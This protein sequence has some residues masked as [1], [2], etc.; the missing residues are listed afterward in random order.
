MKV[1]GVIHLPH[2][3]LFQTLLRT[4]SFLP[5]NQTHGV[6]RRTEVEE[7]PQHSL[8]R[9]R[10][11]DLRQG[12]HHHHRQ[13]LSHR[14]PLGNTYQHRGHLYLRR[15][16]YWTH[17]VGC[18]WIRVPVENITSAGTTIGRPTP[19]RSS[20]TEAA[21]GTAIALIQKKSA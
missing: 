12:R 18:S 1:G 3:L 11:A 6:Q 8:G 4:W 19:A 5:R 17:A 21:M 2:P 14:Q 16:C 20:G 13:L 9:P 10:I 7:T 15:L